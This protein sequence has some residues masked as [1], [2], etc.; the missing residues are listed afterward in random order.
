VIAPCGPE[1]KFMLQPAQLESLIT[2]RTKWIILN[3]PGNPSGSVYSDEDLTALAQVL[4]RHPH[5]WV[6]S[7]DIYEHI[8]FD[9]VIAKNIVQI[10]PQLQ[11]RALLVNGVSKAYAMTGWRIG[12]GAGPAHLIRNMIKLQSQSTSNPNSIAQ[13][14]T[15]EALRGPQ[16]AVKESAARF[17]QR[18]DFVM[19]RLTQI[20]GLDTIEPGGAFYVFPDCRRL[21]GRQSVDGKRIESDSDFVM[22]L[23]EAENLAVLPGEAYGS[24]GFFRL[25]YAASMQVLEAGCER[26]RRACA[27]L[28]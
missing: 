25:S 26:L 15:V 14:A 24:P 17:Q 16:H 4:E 23:L 5:V 11:S 22:Y 7:D 12:Y 2:P 9:G 8:V 19:Q 3:S 1:A 10:A 28:R 6:L 13:A 20:P 27:A 21:Y 18:K